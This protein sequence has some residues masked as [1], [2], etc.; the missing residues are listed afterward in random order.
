MAGVG[1]GN[2]KKGVI[3]EQSELDMEKHTRKMRM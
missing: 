2:G 3:D 1:R